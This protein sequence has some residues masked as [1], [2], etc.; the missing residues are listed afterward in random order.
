MRYITMDQARPQMIV[1]KS[2][3]NEAGQILVNYRVSLTENLIERMKEKHLQG[4]YIIDDLSEDIDVEPLV[5][6]GLEMRATKV[7]HQMDI[8]AA[9]SVASDIADEL[10][11]QGDINVNLVSLRT[12]SDYTFKHSLSVAILST[13][14]GMGMGMKHSALKELAAAGLLHD[15]GKINVPRE[16]LEKPGPLTEEE[17]ATIKLHSS[18][19]YEILKENILITSKIKMGVY[20]HHENMNGTGY[21][22]GLEGDQIYSFARIIH[23][24]DVYDAI[25][26]KRV[27]KKAQSPN[28]AV[29]FLIQN[30][31]KLF[32]PKCVQA[33]VTYIPVYPK[34]RNVV[35][36]DGSVAVV[37]ENRQE[38]T[39]YP[40][41]RRLSDGETIDLSKQDEDGLK[42]LGFQDI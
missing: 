19:G 21:P 37:V 24:A 28:E 38:N 33:F 40:V 10:L 5:S 25:T 42:I 20:M 2:V 18:N 17:Y 11:G 23:V 8:D 3:Y 4:L 29:D 39:L 30:S 41:I 1:G 36:S 12:S 27:Y 7:L 9:M 26:S 13:L 14:I 32:D 15:I 31:G 35:L 22:L 16:I 34:G 6:D